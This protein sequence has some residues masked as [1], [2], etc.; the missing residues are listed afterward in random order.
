M[1]LFGCFSCSQVKERKKRVFLFSRVRLPSRKVFSIQNNYKE[2]IKYVKN[3]VDI[4]KVL[5]LPRQ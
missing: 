5:E 3:P 4:K 2:F 1:N